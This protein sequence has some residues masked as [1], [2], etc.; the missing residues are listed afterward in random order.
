[1]PKGATNAPKMQYITFSAQ[2]GGKEIPRAVDPLLDTFTPDIVKMDPRS[3]EPFIDT[4]LSYGPGVD[5]VPCWSV[6]GV[7]AGILSMAYPIAPFIE[8]FK[9]IPQSMNGG[10]K[11]G[12]E[13]KIFSKSDME[14]YAKKYAEREIKK[15]KI[16]EAASDIDE[17]DKELQRIL[18]DRNYNIPYTPEFPLK[19]YPMGLGLRS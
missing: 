3:Y 12:P 2:K 10:Y 4:N 7:E 1:M 17:K 15:E 6:F 8:L 11:I 19:K 18:S 5:G 9:G 14:S 16:Q 13:D